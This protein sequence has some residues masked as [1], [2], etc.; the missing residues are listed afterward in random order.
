M[1]DHYIEVAD[2]V[3]AAFPDLAVEGIEDEDAAEGLFTVENEAGDALL[4]QS[5]RYLPPAFFLVLY[6]RVFRSPGSPR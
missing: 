1:V 2:A 3:E 4:S 5:S 6:Y